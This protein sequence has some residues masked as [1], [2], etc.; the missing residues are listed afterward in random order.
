M[1]VASSLDDVNMSIASIYLVKN[2]H[3]GEMDSTQCSS[4]SIYEMAS[5]PD[6]LDPIGSPVVLTL[7]LI[8]LNYNFAL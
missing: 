7:K 3:D 1:V 5:I 8:R 6:I 2:M 4:W